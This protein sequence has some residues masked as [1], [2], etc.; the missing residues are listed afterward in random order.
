V[1]LLIFQKPPRLRPKKYFH[2]NKKFVF[3]LSHPALEEKGG[4]IFVL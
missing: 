2:F 1:N 4:E 3:G